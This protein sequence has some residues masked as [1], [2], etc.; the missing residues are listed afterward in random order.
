MSAAAGVA[1]ATTP[2]DRRAAW[3]PVVLALIGLGALLRFVGLDHQSLWLDELLAFLIGQHGLGEA[4]ARSRAI[5]GQSPFYYVVMNGWSAVFGTDSAVVARALSATL[6]V[7]SLA[8][9]YAFGR[10]FVGEP[11][12]R[13]GLVILVLSP[14]HLY[15]SQEARMYPLLLVLVLAIVHLCLAAARDPGARR[16][17]RMAAIALLTAAALYTHYYAVLFLAALDLFLLLTWRRSGSALPWLALAQAAGAAAYLPW[18]PALFQAAEGGGNPFIRFVGL[19]GFYTAFTFALGYSSV[20]LDADTK[21]A[22]P[23]QFLAA[24]PRV[25]LGGLA[26]GALALQGARALWRRDRELL[27]LIALLLL[28]PVGAATL[29]SFR[30]PIISERYFS[31]A[32]PFFAL[33]LGCG[34]VASRGLA[35]WLSVG[36]AGVLVAHS[37]ASYWLDP[38]FGNHDWRAAARW[39]NERRAPGEVLLFHP[40]FVEPC[41]RFYA[42][43]GA[44]GQGIADAAAV[45]GLAAD[46]RYALVVSHPR[47]ELPAIVAALEQRFERVD[48]L[49]L[50]RGEGIRV[51]R[52]ARRPRASTID[53][54]GE[55]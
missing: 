53:E 37:L 4:L 41:F 48:E 45:A 36:I 34:V 21:Q 27:L 7:V 24:W 15:F 54:G 3:G 20:V 8:Q 49:W 1:V 26:F 29:V 14:L 42:R 17:G 46:G 18:V 32:L 28:L 30:L 12:A 51:L 19:K 33:L 16:F 52:Y 5:A 9:L 35:R 47:P 6:G 13:V 31:P 11:E 50:P 39:M 23:Q 10:R 38:R 55:R 2:A 25:L 22:I 43:E 44:P 40:P